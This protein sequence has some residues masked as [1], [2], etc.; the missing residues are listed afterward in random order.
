MEGYDHKE[1]LRQLGYRLGHLRIS[2]GIPA[3]AVAAALGKDKSVV[4]RIENGS[5]TLTMEILLTYSEILQISLKDIVTIEDLTPSLVRFSANASPTYQR[6]AKSILNTLWDEYSKGEAGPLSEQPTG[7][8]PRTRKKSS[9]VQK[10]SASNNSESAQNFGRFLLIDTHE[11][12][13]VLVKNLQRA[14][15]RLVGY[16][17]ALSSFAAKKGMSTTSDQSAD[18]D[19]GSTPEE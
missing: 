11:M 4:S 10:E 3:K 14:M 6:I 8:A 15:G 13:P 16:S 19:T 18:F 9:G 2:S 12:S 17:D 5:Y 1:Y 7:N